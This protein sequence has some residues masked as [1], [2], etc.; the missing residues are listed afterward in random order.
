MFGIDG[1]FA[2]LEND[3]YRQLDRDQVRADRLEREFVAQAATAKTALCANPA[4]V[5]NALESKFEPTA[6]ICAALAVFDDFEAGRLLREL[7]NQ[8]AR[9]ELDQIATDIHRECETPNELVELWEH[10]R[11][12][13]YAS[14][15][16]PAQPAAKSAS[17]PD[18]GAGLFLSNGV[19]P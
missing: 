14:H 4:F 13:T 17:L 1:H 9:D 6:A 18:A 7:V 15:L 12:H 2:R 16:S 11:R 8:H 5:F 19:T 10:H 3:Y